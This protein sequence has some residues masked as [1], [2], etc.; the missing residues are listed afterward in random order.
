L[1]L[2]SAKN[3]FI[4]LLFS[5]KKKSFWFSLRGYLKKFEAEKARFFTK[6]DAFFKPKD[7]I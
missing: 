7:K 4:S 6:I 5:N 2:F 3:E 1:L